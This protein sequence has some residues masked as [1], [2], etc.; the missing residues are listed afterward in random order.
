M[1]SNPTSRGVA[2]AALVLALVSAFT[3]PAG[4]D[5]PPSESD[6][7]LRR[8]EARRREL[9][10]AKAATGSTMGALIHKSREILALLPDS[11]AERAGL[12]VGDVIT[13]MDGTPVSRN[14]IARRLKGTQPGTV[15]RVTVNRDGTSQDIDVSLAPSSHD[16]SLLPIRLGRISVVP[17]RT[18]PGQEVTF[19]I[20]Y[21]VTG[22]GN[23]V[24]VVE[25]REIV[26]DRQALAN[27]EDTFSRSRG[28]FT[29][30][31]PVTVAPQAAPGKYLA[32]ITLSA[33]GRQYRA[34]GEFEVQ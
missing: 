24:Q 12:R 15:V 26:K 30:E 22:G 33:G 32:R 14:D 27:W 23:P 29:S 18:A 10:D 17:A 8:L 13:H 11:P 28:V 5:R 19:T 2:T 9:A 21:W 25:R 20:K 4:A 7:G 31:K 6:A 16:R 1:C 34:Y 3:A